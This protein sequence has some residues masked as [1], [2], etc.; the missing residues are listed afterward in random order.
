MR[1]RGEDAIVFKAAGIA[2][3]RQLNATYFVQDTSN[4]RRR[5]GG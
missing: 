3:V 5:F 2:Q 4:R 1:E